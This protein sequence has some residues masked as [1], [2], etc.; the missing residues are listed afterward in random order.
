MREKAIPSL[1]DQLRSRRRK[2]LTA[3]SLRRRRFGGGP[4]CAEIVLYCYPVDFELNESLR[5]RSAGSSQ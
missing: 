2:A 4:R 3:F 1:F 5:P